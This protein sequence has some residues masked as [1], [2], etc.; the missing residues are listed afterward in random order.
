LNLLA[1]DFFIKHLLFFKYF[2]FLAHGQQ[3]PA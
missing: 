2:I 1:G 3:Q